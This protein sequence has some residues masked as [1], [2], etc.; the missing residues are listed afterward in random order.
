MKKETMVG[1]RLNDVQIGLLDRLIDSS[2]GKI[3]TRSAALQHV[4]N[5]ELILGGDK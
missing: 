5:K 3:K 2:Q 4:L 1:V